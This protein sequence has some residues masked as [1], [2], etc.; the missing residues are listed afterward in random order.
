[1]PRP[2]CSRF[3][4]GKVKSAF[5]KHFGASPRSLG[6]AVSGGS[7]SLGLLVL[8]REWAAESGVTLAVA[9]VD[10]GLRSE[11]KAEAAYVGE[12]CLSWGIAH[13]VLTWSDHPESGNLMAEARI[14]RYRLISSWA[15]ENGI[16]D[17]GLGHTSDDNAETFVMGLMRGAGLDG[18]S[19][20]RPKFDAQGV[21]FHRPLLGV[22]RA[23]LR[24]LLTDKGIDW[25]DD[26]TN[27]DEHYDRVRVR[28]ALGALGGLGLEF[29]KSIANLR[30]TRGDLMQELW[31]KVAPALKVT[32]VDIRIEEES[33]QSLSPEFRRRFLNVVL[34]YVGGHDYPP[35]ADKVQRL[36]EGGYND[37]STLAGALIYLRKGIIHITREP[38]KVD[39]LEANV[40]V[41]WDG[42]IVA[43]GPESDAK[44]RA[45]GEKGLRQIGAIWRETDNPRRSLLA[46]P[47]VWVADEVVFAPYAGIFHPD[48][49]FNCKWS[50]ASLRTFVL[51]H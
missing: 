5:K 11:A 48:W 49:E 47:A 23:D 14:A 6:L 22:S 2:Q 24:A 33:F 37:A 39:D 9:T 42:R 30:A 25:V 16:G 51:T 1:M 20:M 7:D 29:D 40:G 18:L 41:L 50:A 3:P 12:L 10:H 32:P 27:D 4:A 13:E 8:A 44:V 31:S 35:R 43:V 36:A 34:R 45:L 15:E 46:A 21:T 38:N 26:P 28:K 17:V 19:G